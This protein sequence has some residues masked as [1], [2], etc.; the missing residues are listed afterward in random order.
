MRQLR[1]EPYGDMGEV[2]LRPIGSVSKRKYVPPPPQTMEPEKEKGKGKAEEIEKQ[3]EERVNEDAKRQ[4]E[5][6]PVAD[7]TD[8]V[9]PATASGSGP[10]MS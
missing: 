7:W 8:T 10:T 6:R 3:R 1:R 9:T 4:I 5:K 2:P